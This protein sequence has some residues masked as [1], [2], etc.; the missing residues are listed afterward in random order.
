MAGPALLDTFI[1]PLNTVL[2]PDGVLRLRVFEQRYLEMTKQ[3]LRDERPFGVCL[4]TE[5]E[6]VG[7]PAVPAAVGCLAAIA[8]WDMPQ[9]GVF[10][11]TTR[12]GQRF[13]IIESSVSGSGLIT[14]TVETW[15]VDPA[16]APMDMDCRGFLKRV[17]ER[18]GS[19][20]FPEPLQLDDAAWVGYRLAE[21]LPLP[22]EERQSL[23]ELRDAAE[24]L[25]RLRQILAEQG[26]VD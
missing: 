24:R 11:L 4:I 22:N 14:A 3:C 17:I 1:F 5:G 2:F 10:G 7:T 13:R 16:Q 19:E 21:I 25:R 26:L 6:E 18:V 12:G 9:L 8:Q 23:L 15:P 20:H